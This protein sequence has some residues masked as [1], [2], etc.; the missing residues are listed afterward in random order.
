MKHVAIKR[1]LAVITDEEVAGVKALIK[2]EGEASDSNTKANITN[3]ICDWFD[4]M[5]D[6]YGFSKEIQCHV[7]FGPRTICEGLSRE[8]VR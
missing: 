7:N 2:L 5:A 6:K 4:S 8:V 1:V 3:W